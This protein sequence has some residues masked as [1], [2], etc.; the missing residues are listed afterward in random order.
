MT[1]GS[2]NSLHAQKRRKVAES[3]KLCRTKKTR[4]D[5]QH[6]SCT[7]CTAKGQKCEYNPA[8]V[9]VSY[10]TLESIESRLKKLEQQ[11]S[12]TQSRSPGGENS[13]WPE[14][15]ASCPQW[16]TQT[17]GNPT[18]EPGINPESEPSVF[19][20]ENPTTQFMRDIM[21]MAN[22]QSREQLPQ[23]SLWDQNNSLPVETDR[24]SMVVPERATSD[25]LLDSYERL[26]Y[27]LFPVLHMPTFRRCYE[28][29]WERRS[30]DRFKTSV[31]EA[32]FHATLNVVFALGCINDSTTESRLKMRTADCFY[33]RARGILPPDALDHLSLSVA[34]Y[35]LLMSIYF[36]F[37]KYTNRCCNTLAVAIRVCQTLGLQVNDSSFSSNQL[38]QEMRRRTWHICMI[39]ERLYCSVFG[40]KTMIA[41]DFS[42]P[43]PANI[44]DEYLKEEGIGI[45]PAG[46]PSVIEA[47]LVIINIFQVIED[48]QKLKYRSAD[49]DI[50]L[51]ELTQVLELNEKIDEIERSL[52]H[53]LKASTIESLN[54]P[55]DQVLRLQ[56]EGIMTRILY[57]RL[58]LLRPYVLSAAR[59]S[60]LNPQKAGSLSQPP[61][62]I[63]STIRTEISKICVQAAMSA[64]STLHTNLRFKSRIFSCNAVFMTLNATAVIIGASLI[65]EL[66]INIDDI[67]THKTALAQAF[68]VLEEH[69]WQIEG[70]RKIIER[71]TKFL[72]TVRRENSRRL[73][74]LSICPVEGNEQ[75]LNIDSMIEEFD[76]NDPI[77]TLQWSGPS[78]LFN[79]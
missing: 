34:Q 16:R 76:F 79:T 14:R 38:N 64:I 68:E 60:L 65:S 21:Q 13:A 54:T 3:C 6:P 57:A 53:Y 49:Q 35:L 43:L 59:K 25:N 45:Q 4:C 42:V 55:H 5:G 37:T 22:S 1:L 73:S 7:S 41:N 8:T 40:L 33:R 19:F 17:Y 58:A 47:T 74:G 28:R 15:V 77:W 67:G 70:G 29:L 62:S 56:A 12:D 51:H 23:E 26:V 69:V 48:A 78:G 24:L 39:L 63:H 10:D 36:S 30:P 11:V 2:T 18:P 66:G 44:D 50:D 46:R 20:G 31:E 72:E 9:P 75:A 61:E 32:V 27:P 52:P 71:L